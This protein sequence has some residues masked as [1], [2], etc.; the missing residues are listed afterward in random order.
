MSWGEN[1][2]TISADE[3]VPTSMRQSQSSARAGQTIW[4]KYDSVEQDIKQPTGY[5]WSQS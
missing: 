2:I 1:Y 5:D 3:A 4:S